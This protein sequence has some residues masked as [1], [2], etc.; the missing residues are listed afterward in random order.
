MDEGAVKAEDLSSVERSWEA[1]RDAWVAFAQV[2]YPSAVDAIRAQITLDR[3]RLVK[4][5]S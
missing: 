3:Y 1:Y 5:I 2:R 4:T